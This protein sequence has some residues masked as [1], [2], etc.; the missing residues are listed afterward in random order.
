MSLP[1]S[2]KWIFGI[3][4]AL[5]VGAIG[6][7]F[8][9]WF[10]RDLFMW[11]GRGILSL[12]TLGVDS[13]RDSFYAEIAQ[14]RTERVG[15]FL[16]TFGLMFLGLLGGILT[17]Q[18]AG[19]S[20]KTFFLPLHQSRNLKMALLVSYFLVMF[21]LM[22]RHVSVS[23]TSRAVEHFEQM[24][25]IC[26]PTLPGPER[27]QIRSDFACMKTRADY[28]KIIENLEAKARANN[29]NVPSFSIW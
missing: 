8:W 13:V 29:R 1:R 27:D 10:L 28:I 11:C 22:F 20:G 19:E 2:L 7:G 21:S 18:T 15:L 4:G 5:F 17:R 6:N 14:G 23:Y 9:E 25:T 16:A 24:L 3:V 26:L 12:I